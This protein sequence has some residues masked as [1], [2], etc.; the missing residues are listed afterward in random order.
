MEVYSEIGDDLTTLIL[1]PVISG[2]NSTLELS[3]PVPVRLS[4]KNGMFLAVNREMNLEGVG[5]KW[6]EALQMFMNFFFTQFMTY[7]GLDEE[8]LMPNE[9]EQ[10]DIIRDMIPD[11]QRQLE[12][13]A[14]K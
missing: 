13:I 10:W 11:W 8:K 5:E 1:L 6:D 4:L 9:K 3:V 14:L 12:R 2:H 7:V